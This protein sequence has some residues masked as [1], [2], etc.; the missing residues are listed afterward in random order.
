MCYVARFTYM[1]R[2][3]EAPTCCRAPVIAF[4]QDTR[5]FGLLPSSRWSTCCINE[6]HYWSSLKITAEATI[7]LKAYSRLPS[8]P[9]ITTE[10]IQDYLRSYYEE[11]VHLNGSAHVQAKGC[12]ELI[13]TAAMY[14]S[15]V[16]IF[17]KAKG[18]YLFF[19]STESL[20]ILQAEKPSE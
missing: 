17:V 14:M 13:K 6:D 10:A 8:K 9:R 1:M 18:N 20:I 4:Q 15:T 19:L 12:M 2:Y 16:L 3:G 7:T 5:E 11:I